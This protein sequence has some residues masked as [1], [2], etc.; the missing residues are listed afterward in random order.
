ME[1]EVAKKVVAPTEIVKAAVTG[2]PVEPVA[3]DQAP[4]KMDIDTAVD[5]PAD[6]NA[7]VVVPSAS[8][9]THE[10]H[11]AQP[12]TMDIVSGER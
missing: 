1:A 8:V 7:A 10:Q 3:D 4:K 11:S 6:P 5:A 2:E 12:K 9:T